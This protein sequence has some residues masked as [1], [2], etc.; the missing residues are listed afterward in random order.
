MADAIPFGGSGD[1]S[2]RERIRR[3]LRTRCLH[4][5]TKAAVHPLPDSDEPENPYDTAI[6]WCGETTEA[7][8]PDGFAAEPGT[9]D[10]AGR[11]CYRSPRPPPA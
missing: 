8:G 2:A 10:A 7:L 5:C 4:L 1:S 6:W 11:A 9:C 3:V